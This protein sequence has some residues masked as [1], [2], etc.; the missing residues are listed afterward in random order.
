MKILILGLTGSGKS[1]CAKRIA[2]KFSLML[3]EA[4]DEVLRLNRGV[5]PKQESVIDKYFEMTNDEVL[6]KDTILYVISWLEKERIKE[7]TNKGFKIIELHA[8]MDELLKRKQHRDDPSTEEINRFWTNYHNYLRVVNDPKLK[9]V[10][11]LKLD[12]TNL[13][14]KQTEELVLKVL[15]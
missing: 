7:F 9:N 10:F 13:A 1:T 14:P 3:V 2:E 6:R 5:W 8:D 11:L 4:D 15:V 12:T